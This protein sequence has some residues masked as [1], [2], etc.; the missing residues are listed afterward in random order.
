MR[1]QE[2]DLW[3][4]AFFKGWARLKISETPWDTLFPQD[5]TASCERQFL[6]FFAAVKRSCV[7]ALFSCHDMGFELTLTKRKEWA[8]WQRPDSTSRCGTRPFEDSR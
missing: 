5:E 3:P 1:Q 2:E 4:F 7:F 6:H 8:S